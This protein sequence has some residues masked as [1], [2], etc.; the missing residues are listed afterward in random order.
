MLD[1]LS[2][3]IYQR[4][5]ILPELG[6]A[7]QERLG[8]ASV[9]VVGCG[10][11]GSPLLLYLAAMG[12]GR[13]GLVD[14]DLV[15]LSNLNRQILYGPEDVGQPKAQQAAARLRQLNPRLK[16]EVYP[17]YLTRENAARLLAGYDMAADCLD[18]FG[19]RL[20]LNDACL[21]AGLPFVHAGVSHLSGQSM[22]VLPGRTP[23]LRCLFGDSL[24]ETQAAA[25]II[26]PTPGLLACVQVT[27]IYKY[28]CGLPPNP[29]LLLYDGQRME[30]RTLEL[31]P[32]PDC[33]C[34]QLGKK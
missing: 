18:N 3:N 23:C 30:T 6:E 2:R 19:A 9:L 24:P 25:G 16:L 15:S 14:G 10:G 13:L 29:G 27:E 4:Q 28:F 33:R 31:R 1:E 32:N 34:Q 21:D 20:I 8:S 11:L 7:G 5:I 26:G 17:E 22:T 12:I